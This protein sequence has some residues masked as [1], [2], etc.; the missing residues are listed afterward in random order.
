MIEI[1]IENVSLKAQL[2]H[3]NY[4]S[5]KKKLL[6]RKETK[7]VNIIDNLSLHL[8]EG[9]K[10]GVIGNNGDG[11]TTFLRLISGIHKPT[12]GSIYRNGSLASFIDLNIGTNINFSGL[13]NIILKAN[14]LGIPKN[15]LDSKLEE[16][17]NFSGLKDRV[18]SKLS[19]YS[20]GMISRL[21]FS[22][23]LLI[24]SDILVLDEIFEVGDA[25]F[26]QKSIDLIT[27]VYEKSSIFVF[28][29]HNLPLIK[30]LCNKLIIFDEGKV[31]FEGNVEEGI[32]IYEKKIIKDNLS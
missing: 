29:S 26:K 11:K 25:N 18:N 9:T 4:Y 5:L 17:I 7:N 20:S 15:I 27:S 14:M 22:I 31:Y 24:K 3:E 13:D 8:K 23:L 6:F 30:K 12:N 32:N 1:K 21:F 10:L 16:I 19:T 28:A 2:K